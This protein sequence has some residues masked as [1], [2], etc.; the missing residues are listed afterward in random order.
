MKFVEIL[1]ICCNLVDKQLTR[2]HVYSESNYQNAL[3][4]YLIRELDPKTTICREVNIVYRLS[5][6]FVFG[7]GRADIVVETDSNCY[8][9]ELKANVDCKHIKKFFGQCAKYTRHYRT[10]LIKTGIVV[11]FNC[12]ATPIIKVLP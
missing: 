2:Q 5:D 8:I 6:G 3:I 1:N 11:L 12:G 9:L 10:N 7:S 4:H